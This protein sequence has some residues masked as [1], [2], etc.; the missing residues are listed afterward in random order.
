MNIPIGV[1]PATA[2]EAVRDFANVHERVAAGFVTASRLDN[3]DRIVTFETGAQARERLID[4][5]DER[6]RLVYSVIDSSLGFIHHQASV[7][8]VAT[9]ENEG[10]SRLVWTADLL[11]DTLRP[12]VEA[13]MT[14]GASAIARRSPAETVTAWMCC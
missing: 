12:V 4:V 6:R 11:P 1:D 2:W 8:V 7:E 14:Q 5:D 13:M 3:G 9:A 10:R